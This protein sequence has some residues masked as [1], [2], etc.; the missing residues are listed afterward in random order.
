M[1][2]RNELGRWC[3][4]LALSILM[5]SL[6]GCSEIF[7]KRTPGEKLYRKHC[8][9]CHGIDGS[10]HTI[11]SMGDQDANLLDSR[12]KHSGDAVGMENVIREALV[13]E[14]P[15]FDKLSR[16]EVK[17]IVDHIFSLRGERR[18]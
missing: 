2:T 5:L 1:R 3:R 8:A 9:D 7:P 15:T 11:R 14:H 6:G 10:G 12:W 13:F 18:K 4:G 17:Q 16:E